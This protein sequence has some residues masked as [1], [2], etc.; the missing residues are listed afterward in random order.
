MSLRMRIL[1]DWLLNSFMKTTYFGIVLLN[2]FGH[3]SIKPRPFSCLYRIKH[4]FRLRLYHTQEY[5]CYKASSRN[6]QSWSIYPLSKYIATHRDDSSTYINYLVD[7][8]QCCS[9]T[10]SY[11]IH[12][13][14]LPRSLCNSSLRNKSRKFSSS[15]ILFVI[16]SMFIWVWLA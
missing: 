4:W 2:T 15:Q 7:V 6:S 9:N 8:G 14:N 13:A 10:N 5:H 16:R 1:C 11:Y 3:L 12:I